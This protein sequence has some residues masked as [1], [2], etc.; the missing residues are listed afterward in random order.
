MR[1]PRTED[2][3]IL[4]MSELALHY[5]KGN[6]PLSSVAAQHGLSAL[7]LKN[8]AR[9]LKSAGLIASREGAAGGYILA[10]DPK[11]ISVWQITEA[12]KRD[13]F[14]DVKKPLFSGA[15]PLTNHCIPEIIRRSLNNAVESGL[16]SINLTD[17]ISGSYE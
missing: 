6:I 7:F 15:C 8:L 11:V 2:T 9:K 5:Q 13:N 10:R 17:L 3:A 14:T 12:V 1:I 4:L 16:R